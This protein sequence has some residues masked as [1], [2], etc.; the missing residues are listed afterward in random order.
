MNSQNVFFAKNFFFF[1]QENSILKDGISGFWIRDYLVGHCL[2]FRMN[3]SIE[4]YVFAFS[5]VSPVS[6]AFIFFT[7]AGLMADSGGYTASSIFSSMR[8]SL[9]R[10]SDRILSIF[11]LPGVPGTDSITHGT[12]SMRESPEVRVVFAFPL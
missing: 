12:E 8:S 9:M 6:I 3:S 7:Y 1:R 5:F 4:A 11:G 10:I 2:I